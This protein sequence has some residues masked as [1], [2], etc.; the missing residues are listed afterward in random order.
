MSCEDVR[1][2]VEE[3]GGEIREVQVALELNQKDECDFYTWVEEQRKRKLN[4]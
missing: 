3:R 4:W 1:H 2:E